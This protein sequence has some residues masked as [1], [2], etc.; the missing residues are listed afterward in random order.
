MESIVVPDTDTNFEN[1]REVAGK[2]CDSIDN[3][4]DKE[5]TETPRL[6]LFYSLLLGFDAKFR[7]EK[8]VSSRSDEPL[9][10]L[11]SF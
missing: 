2:H 10:E 8:F 7:G 9:C 3:S 1:E 11:T 6:T 4:Q 5:M